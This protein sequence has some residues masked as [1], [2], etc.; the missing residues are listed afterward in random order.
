M[1]ANG[2]NAALYAQGITANTQLR[3]Y[4][5]VTATSDAL[6]PYV[7]T[8]SNDLY[9]GNTALVQCPCWVNGNPRNYIGAPLA[10]VNLAVFL[11]G[12]NP[13]PVP[14]NNYNAPQ[15]APYAG[16]LTFSGTKQA[17][18]SL[19]SFGVIHDNICQFGSTQNKH[20]IENYIQKLDECMFWYHAQQYVA[21]Q[22]HL[23]SGPT[24]GQ[25]WWQYLGPD[26]YHYFERI[27]GH[28]N[29][30]GRP[31]FMIGASI[32]VQDSTIL[33][34]YHYLKDPVLY[35]QGTTVYLHPNLGSVPCQNLPVAQ[36]LP[37]SVYPL[38]SQVDAVVNTSAN[39]ASL[40]DP[41]LC[42]FDTADVLGISAM[43]TRHSLTIRTTNV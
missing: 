17:G 18:T 1:Y 37:A 15:S 35:A 32:D 14:T 31:A 39:N 5:P 7:D 16:V 29:K 21:N 3:L 22:A 23:W 13:V 19:V 30:V 24:Y 38:T 36:R 43:A 40:A 34:V 42:S 27:S 20:P 33:D 25:T 26:P 9:Y 28:T 4:A 6:S 12:P 10:T 11:A 8:S 41:G 2:H